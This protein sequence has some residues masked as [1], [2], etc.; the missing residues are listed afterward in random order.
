[1]IRSERR[2]DPSDAC[3]EAIGPAGVLARA[4]AG[5]ALVGLAL[6]WR[7]PA[8]QDAALGLVALPAVA[9][10]TLAARARIRPRA[11]RAGGPL[12]H[13]LNAIVAIALFTQPATGGAAMLFYGASMIIASARRQGGCE[14]TVV[15]NAVLRRD[16]QVGCPL[17]LP[18]D[19]IQAARRRP[20]AQRASAP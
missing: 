15:A 20:S 2:P 16:D 1:M 3:P 14:A 8:W 13:A 11:L 17:F 18:V 5:T 10:G 7:D 19:A 9:V 6:F 12:A 4:L